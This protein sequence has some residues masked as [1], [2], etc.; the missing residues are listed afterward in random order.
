MSDQKTEEKKE[1]TIKAS[2][3]HHQDASFLLSVAPFEIDSHHPGKWRKLHSEIARHLGD[4]I[5][6]LLDELGYPTLD[7][8]RHL[9][10]LVL[11]MCH[12]HDTRH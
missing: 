12:Q 9:E 8:L 4:P 7:K 11:R 5:M 3:H 2:K 1:K 6:N 10:V